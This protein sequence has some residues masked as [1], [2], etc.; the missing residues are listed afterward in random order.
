MELLDA[1]HPVTHDMGLIHADPA[2]I[3]ASS[4][5]RGVFS[6]GRGITSSLSDALEALPPLSVEKTRALFVSLDSGWTAFFSSGIQ[7]SDPVPVVSTLARELQVLTMRLCS[8]P[9]DARFAANVWEVFAPSEL[10]G[11]DP[12]G[13]RRTVAAANDGG[14]WTFVQSGRPFEFEDLDAYAAPRKRDRLTRAHLQRYAAALGAHPFDE[15]SYRVARTTPALLVTRRTPWD[16]CP[17]EFALEDV[18]SGKPWR[19][20]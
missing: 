13:Y 1:W 4:Y 7:G 3:V 16:R 5:V 9:P 20:S 6:E 12:L 8:T 15:A 11:T 14:R 17:P 10:G 2:R 18:R 19:S